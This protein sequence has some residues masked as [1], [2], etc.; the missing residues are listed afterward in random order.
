M[1]SGKAWR[2]DSPHKLRTRLRLEE[3]EARIVPYN[4]TGNA[5]P[6]PELITLSFVPD[7]TLLGYNANGPVYSTL[8]HD[9]NTLFGSASKWEKQILLAANSW[10]DATNIN[11]AVVTDNGADLGSINGYNQQGDPNFGDIRIAGFQDTGAGYL[12][13]AFQPP[14][15]NNYSIAGDLWFNTSQAFHIGTTYDLYTVVAHEIGHALGMDHSG[16][17]TAVMAP[18]YPGTRTSLTPDD[19]SGIES[20]YSAG[21]RRSYDAYNQSLPHN[22]TFLTAASF[23]VNSSTL[24]AQLTHI[25]IT[26]IG[27]NE[28][29]KF[30]APTGSST[31]HLSIQSS[32]LS[33]LSPRVWV[34]N[35]S[36]TQV[37]YLSGANTYGATLNV[38]VTGL[39]AGRIYYI[40]VNG[41]ESTALGTGLYAL[42]LSTGSNAVPTVT[43]PNTLTPNGDPIS[44]GNSE[45]EDGDTYLAD[46]PPASI[47]ADVPTTHGREAGM[48]DVSVNYMLS[49]EEWTRHH[50]Q[51]IVTGPH[52]KTVIERGGRGT[53][54]EVQESAVENS[55]AVPS[56]FPKK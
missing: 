45:A 24:T 40:K 22:S 11:F 52:V 1:F 30:I 32:G 33:L 39:I 9:F 56:L 37:A 44:S 21:A 51:P 50:A 54:T 34:Y 14:P 7:G 26:T 8:F 13:Q 4:T 41:S 49:T 29:F 17:P 3:L 23:A 46:A 28:Y 10:A 2:S 6:H 16:D 55:D 15:V 12:A 18:S 27:M 36:Q 20:I 48:L 53:H 19:I 43:L 38:T 5:W 47:T 25:D 31:L 35:S 42:S